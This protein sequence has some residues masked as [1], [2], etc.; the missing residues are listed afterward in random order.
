MPLVLV[1]GAG[2]VGSAVAHRLFRAGYGVVVVDDPRPA[3]A[4]R[5]MAFTDAFHEGTCRLDDLLAKRARDVDDLPPMARCGRAVPVTDAP[6]DLVLGIL[7]PDILVDARMRKR[8]MPEPQR[9]L[10]PLTVGLGPNFV[11]GEGVDVAVETSWGEALGTVIRR[12][13][14]RPLAGDPRPIAGHSRDRYVAAPDDGLFVTTR[15]IG[16]A[17]APGDEVARIGPHV[18][19][20]PLAGILRGLTHEGARVSRGRKVIEV[21]PRGDPR[22]AFGIGERPAR[23][24]SGVQEAIEGAASA[25][26]GRGAGGG[27]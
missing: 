22:A 26:P 24:A 8:A 20:A 25:A 14:P 4:R 11:A 9:G 27:T 6:A 21:D 3:H 10:A 16:E 2:D 5:G 19:V 17:V 23:I 7:R 15:A 13:S 12:G 18:L 1:R